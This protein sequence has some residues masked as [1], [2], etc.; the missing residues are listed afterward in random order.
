MPYKSEAQRRYFNANREKLEAEGVDVDEWNESSKGKKLPEKAEKEAFAP[1]TSFADGYDEGQLREALAER[2]R[3]IAQLR[4]HRDALLDDKVASL[5]R[6]AAKEKASSDVLD[7]A[8]QAI[9]APISAARDAEKER[10]DKEEKLQ[11]AVD[12]NVRERMARQIAKQRVPK[13][14]ADVSTTVS[15]NRHPEGV[16]EGKTMNFDREKLAALVEKLKGRGVCVPVSK[17]KGITISKKTITVAKPKKKE[18]K[19]A[20]LLCHRQRLGI[21]KLAAEKIAKRELEKQADIK[22]KISELLK[23][24]AIKGGLI[25]AGTG[26]AAGGLA[27]L[28]SPAEED[29]SRLKLP[30]SAGVLGASVG[31]LAGA[32]GQGGFYT[33]K[34]AYNPV[35]EYRPDDASN[36]QQSNLLGNAFS[37]DVGQI[38]RNTGNVL[39]SGPIY[40]ANRLLGGSLQR[41]GLIRERT[42]PLGYTEH[43]QLPK[44][45]AGTSGELL[46]S[47][48]RAVDKLDKGKLQKN[49]PK[50]QH[51]AAVNAFGQKPTDRLRHFGNILAGSRDG[52]YDSPGAQ[53]NT[54]GHTIDKFVGQLR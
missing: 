49:W 3:M 34:R 12:R 16:V 10:R 8:F 28:L 33:V 53:P 50:I 1:D 19:A 21:A 41:H 6:R 13:I 5:A 30:G 24:K 32:L 15:R 47:V 36:Q 40:G 31:S 46:N 51:Q 2:V 11:K 52:Y 22:A 26:L 7:T 18:K 48:Y 43:A 38:A 35:H 20:D 39:G 14:G 9:S 29:E 27:E 44:P 17:P 37:K 42:Y 4:A 25:G 54:S 45:Q 23:N